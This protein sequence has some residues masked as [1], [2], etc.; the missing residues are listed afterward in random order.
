MELPVRFGVGRISA[1][2]APAVVRILSGTSGVLF[3]AAQIDLDVDRRLRATELV[4]QLR[5]AT[6]EL[7]DAFQQKRS[8]GVTF[9]F[10]SQRRKGRRRFLV[11]LDDLN[12]VASLVGRDHRLFEPREAAPVQAQ[13]LRRFLQARALVSRDD[14][15]FEHLREELLVLELERTERETAGHLARREPRRVLEQ[16]T[17]FF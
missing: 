10:D 12:L 2:A 14:A 11:V 16:R 17:A 5:D 9:R 8:T 13:V 6:F 15:V 3:Q 7:L 4:F 1:D